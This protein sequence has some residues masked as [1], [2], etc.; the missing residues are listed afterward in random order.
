M[1][2]ILRLDRGIYLKL[3]AAILDDFFIPILRQMDHRVRPDNDKF[4]RVYAFFQTPSLFSGPGQGRK[5]Y[6]FQPLIKNPQR[7]IPGHSKLCNFKAVFSQRATKRTLA[8]S[9]ESGAC[10]W[11]ML[12]N[13]SKVGWPIAS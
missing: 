5:T 1:I 7:C 10:H 6:V 11:T 3:I 9:V 8:C 2:V 12:G 13:V 4:E